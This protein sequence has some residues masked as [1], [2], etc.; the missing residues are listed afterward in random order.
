[1]RGR[2]LDSSSSVLLGIKLRSGEGPGR[3]YKAY[4][5]LE[6]VRWLLPAHQ[7]V[8]RRAGIRGLFQ[9]GSLKGR[10]L[11]SSIVTGILPGEEVRLD[12]NTLASLETEL[13]RFLDEPQVRLAFYM[14]VPAPH[15]KVTAQVLT[16]DGETLAYAKIATSSLA[17]AALERER[18]ALTRLGGCEALHGEIPLVLGCFG[19]QGGTVHLLTKGPARF[20][21]KRLSYMHS[22]FCKNLFLCTNEE[23]L[24]AE[25]P[26]WSRMSETWLRLTSASPEAAPTHLGLAL[27]RL[28]REFGSVSV[29]LSMAHGD[30]APWNTRQRQRSLFVFDWERAAE[31][32]TPLYDV[33][34]FQ[35]FQAALYSRRR[36]LPDHRFLHTLLDALWPEGR[37]HLA[38]LYLA[39]LVDVSL[40][41]SEAQVLAPG[42]GE[43]RI[44][45]WLLQQIDALSSRDTPL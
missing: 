6:R 20:G 44:L 21:S 41:Y 34:N 23:R 38:L 12:G 14:G 29:P 25:S 8:M 16:P 15:R 24:F 45:R 26:M 43:T 39:Y 3:Q 27:E 40:L 10:A 22:D 2:S 31:G 1:M 9:P 30:F 32:V 28:Y 7:P 17:E 13:V 4:P 5:D 18:R 37:K 11:R 42:V 19:W 33:F 36:A 35:T